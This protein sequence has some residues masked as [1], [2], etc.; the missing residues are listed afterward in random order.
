MGEL[1]L[2]QSERQEVIDAE[3]EFKN[4]MANNLVE[5]DWNAWKRWKENNTQAQ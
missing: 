3:C 4:R 1:N 5:I 2:D